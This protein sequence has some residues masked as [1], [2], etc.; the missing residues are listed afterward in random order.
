MNETTV[1]RTA[2][3]TQENRERADRRRGTSRTVRDVRERLT[4]YGAQPVFDYEIALGYARNKLSS[5]A[6]VALL[7]LAIA[8]T[9]SHWYPIH[10]LVTWLI[11]MLM[12]HTLNGIVCSRF[13]STPDEKADL[14]VWRRQFL[15]TETLFGF[16]FATLF[17]LPSRD[18]GQATLF[19]FGALLIFMGM[20]TTVASNMPR[21][22]AAAV[23]P[24]AVTSAIAFGMA[25]ST[26]A[27]TMAAFAVIAASYFMLLGFRLNHTAL[28]M[29]SY[30]AEKD[31]L[32]GEL[33]QA[34]AVSD[35]SRRRAEEA[36]LAKSRFL[37]T[38]S[39]ELRTP[40][41]AILGFSEIMQGEVFGPV[42]NDH[43]K[44]YITDIHNSGK[45][46]LNLIN[47]IL[48]LS[49]IEAGKY[50]LNEEAV[51]LAHVVEDCRHLIALRARNKTI[52]IHEHVDAGLPKL[53]ADERALRQVV[54]NLLSNAVKFTQPGGDV[55]VRV[56][57]AADGG[58]FISVRDNGPGIP[59][60]EIPIV[61]TAFGQGSLAIKT[62]EQGTGLGLPIVQALMQMHGG[63]LTLRSKLREGTEVVVAFPATRAMEVMPALDVEV[64]PPPAPR[65]LT[66]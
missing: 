2:D 12:A 3:R 51:T 32:I 59:E 43:Y 5:W 20:T 7:C 62:A 24:P 36:N 48:D 34:K 18:P 45:H 41:N 6:A 56:G 29:L 42:G 11:V 46:L 49:R 61:L 40:L 17:L 25:G 38:M 27:Y 1:G 54:L 26:Q 44:G 9:A 8:V 58:Q 57:R 28:Q 13:V 22:V 66:G 33:E 31:S 60:E 19:V 37:A 14:K 47:E 53:W 63:S 52:A 21:A 4:S 65:R 50:E 10:I 30:R 35:D 64:A 23:L 15:V 16:A 39:H 55:W